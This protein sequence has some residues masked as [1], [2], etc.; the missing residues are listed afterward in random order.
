MN[1]QLLTADNTNAH[2]LFCRHCG[3]Q[4][5]GA[6]KAQH[7]EHEAT[8]AHLQRVAGTSAAGGGGDDDEGKEKKEPTEIVASCWRIDDMWDF[9]NFGQSRPVAGA[10]TS[11]DG[12]DPITPETVYVVCAECE[13]GPVGVRWKAGE[14]YYL[15]HTLLAYE[16]K[17][18]APVNGTLPAGM[19]EEFVRQL[20]AQREEQQQGQDGGEGAEPPVIVMEESATAGADAEAASETALGSE[21]KQE[22]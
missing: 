1:D 6:G 7:E 22:E 4:F 18:G 9:D 10:A 13:K 3:S 8:R 2:P 17:E 15:A 11:G 20:I 19:S 14:P 21:Q 5:L 16:M 12:V